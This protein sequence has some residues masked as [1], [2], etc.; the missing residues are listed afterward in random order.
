MIEIQTSGTSLEL[1]HRRHRSTSFIASIAITINNTFLIIHDDIDL[2][3]IYM[4]MYTYV[5][6]LK[7]PCFLD[8]M[9]EHLLI[10]YHLAYFGDWKT[11]YL[12]ETLCA[13]RNPYLDVSEAVYGNHHNST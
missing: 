10:W 1:T 13:L 12:F 5:S 6:N 4:Y 8:W 3:Y 11:A 9:F 2:L 7:G